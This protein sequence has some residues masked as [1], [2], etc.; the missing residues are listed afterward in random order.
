MSLPK[1]NQEVFETKVNFC[2]CD[3]DYPNRPEPSIS[4]RNEAVSAPFYSSYE[5]LREQLREL[6]K[7]T[8]AL[9]NY[10]PGRRPAVARRDEASTSSSFYP[11]LGE[12]APQRPFFDKNNNLVCSDGTIMPPLV[13]APWKDSNIWL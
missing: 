11:K 7:S 2:R 8:D 3:G 13:K 1:P 9:P 10:A 12:L 4:R 5:E 6:E